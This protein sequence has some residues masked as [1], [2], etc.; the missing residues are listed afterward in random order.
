MESL[1]H[2]LLYG[3]DEFNDKINE[4]FSVLFQTGVMTLGWKSWEPAPS[5]PLFYVVKMK[6]TRNKGK[7]EKVSKQKLL[8]GCHQGQNITF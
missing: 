1:L 3:S 6:K 2:A 4:Y 7:K 5:P 8:K